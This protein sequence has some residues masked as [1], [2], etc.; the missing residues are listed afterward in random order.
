MAEDAI[1]GVVVVVVVWMA[2]LLEFGQG[3]GYVA[4][5]PFYDCET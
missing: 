4:G 1:V 2:L 3:L 5:G